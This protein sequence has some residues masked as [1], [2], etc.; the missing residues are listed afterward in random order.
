MA[1]KLILCCV[2]NLWFLILVS[3]NRVLFSL[4]KCWSVV[5][6]LFMS[7]SCFWFRDGV[8]CRSF[9]LFW[10]IDRGVCILWEVFLENFWIVWKFCFV[11]FV[12]VDIKVLSCWNFWV[13]VLGKFRGLD[14]LM[15]KFWMLFRMC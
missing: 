2:W 14:C 6:V 13:V 7:W 11:C 9:S 10:V 3:S 12:I 15:L 8:F 5:C 4:D 1:E